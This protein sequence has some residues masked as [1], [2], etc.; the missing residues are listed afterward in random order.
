MQPLLTLGSHLLSGGE[1]RGFGDIGTDIKEFGAQT[2]RQLGM[3]RIGRES[4]YLGAKPEG[5][6]GQ[7]LKAKNTYL[8]QQEHEKRMKQRPWE[9]VF[10]K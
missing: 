9:K 2:G 7:R 4:D 5:Y 8:Q 3:G 6:T 10:Y 1:F